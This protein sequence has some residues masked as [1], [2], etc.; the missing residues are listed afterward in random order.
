MRTSPLSALLGKAMK[1][2]WLGVLVLGLILG[3]VVVKFRSYGQDI[4]TAFQAT[5]PQL[6]LLALLVVGLSLGINASTW[7]A[8]LNYL[9]GRL[10]LWEAFYVYFTSILY[11]YVPGSVWYLVSRTALGGSKGVSAGLI[12]MS[13]GMELAIKLATG[14]VIV[15]IGILL[16]VHLDP[17]Q[18][19]WLGLWICAGLLALVAVSIFVRDGAL[20]D[21]FQVREITSLLRRAPLVA[22]LSWV[23]AYTATWFTQGTSLFLILSMWQGLTHRDF[24]TI[25]VAYAA[26]WVAGF[27]NPF[28]P[29]GVGSREA[30][31]IVALSGLVSAPEAL[32]ASITMRVLGLAGES[33]WALVSLAS[34]HMSSRR[35][36]RS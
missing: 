35:A 19:L 6:G 7:R 12:L 21:R 26:A 18:T 33:T 5:R 24:G 13:T 27:V 3:V 30:V 1:S 32:L 2:R 15:A 23:L 14:V 25:M 29:S 8:I 16:G 9:G 31:L 4:R 22:L 10:S 11:R 17:S 34:Q 28:T 36:S 20:R